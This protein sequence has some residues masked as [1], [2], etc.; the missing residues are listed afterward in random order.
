M[1]IPVGERYQQTLYL[2]TK[3]NGKLEA[4]PLRPT[5]FVPMTG[6]AEDVR[7]VQPDGSKPAIINGSFEEAPDNADAELPGWYYQREQSWEEDAKAPQGKHFITFRN[8]VLGRTAHALQGLAIDGRKVNSVDLSAWA[9]SKEVLWGKEKDMR[10]M[11]A[12]TLYD[13]ER[14]EMGT[15]WLGPWHG[16]ND[17]HQ[18]TINIRIPPTAREG[19]LRIGLFGATGEVSFDDVRLKAGK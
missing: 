3:N 15:S 13:G 7:V 11:V 4:E 19:I 12:L 8:D 18:K 16:D 2:F 1:V 9:K 17:W 5:L 14:R 10:P 6:K